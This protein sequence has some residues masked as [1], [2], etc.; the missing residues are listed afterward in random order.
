VTIVTTAT[1]SGPTGTT[2]NAFTALSLRPPQVL[3]CLDNG[4]RTLGQL[5]AA[6]A[7]A[8]NILGA[9]QE[10]LARRSADKALTGAQ[11]WSEMGDCTLETGAPVVQGVIGVL[12]CRLVHCWEGED[13]T[14][15]V[16]EVVAGSVCAQGAPL[17]F[18]AGEYRRLA[19]R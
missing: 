8:V 15:V 10:E 9:E 17:L 14:V 5:L 13:H 11:R 4:S 3:L 1:A 19:P 7:F 16:G 6:G 18:Y 2:V 12:D